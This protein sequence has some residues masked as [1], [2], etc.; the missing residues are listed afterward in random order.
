[1]AVEQAIN[2]L[3]AAFLSDQIAVEGTEDYKKLNNSYL[4][5]LQSEIKPATIFLPRNKHDVAKFVQLIAPFALDGNIH[6]AI[7]GAGQQPVPGCS[8]IEGDG[9]T[10]DLRHL[11][12][13]RIKDGMVS[14][15][16]GERWGAIY[17]KLAE[18]GL[19][20]TGSR[21]ALGGIGGLALAGNIGR[22]I[23]VALFTLTRYRWPL[24]LL[25]ARR[26]HLRQRRE[27]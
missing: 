18:Q 2:T 13:I 6:F 26:L 4:S 3:R 24:F 22:F 23:F 19:G 5:L 16:A 17:E 9:I 10:I 21:S 11:T 25:L 15:G 14:L 7:R 12:G 8:N 1:M 27:L 20:V